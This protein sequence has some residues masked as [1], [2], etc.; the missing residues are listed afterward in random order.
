VDEID[1][2]EEFRHQMQQWGYADLDWRDS[3]SGYGVWQDPT[4]HRVAMLVERRW[5]PC[6]RECVP[7]A[8]WDRATPTMVSWVSR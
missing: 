3:P 2:A 1:W 4:A 8:L 6:N 5:V 7:S